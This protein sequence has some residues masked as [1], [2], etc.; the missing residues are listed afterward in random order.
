MRYKELLLIKI[1]DDGMLLRELAREIK[2]PPPS[3]HNYIYQETE[4]R[5]E[6]LEKM[7][8]YFR[9]PVSQLLSEDDDTTAQILSIVRRMNP[10]EKQNLLELLRK[11]R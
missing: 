2:I 7:S 1:V 6:A 3:L 11:Q 9:E 4:P 10:N 5:R 8:V